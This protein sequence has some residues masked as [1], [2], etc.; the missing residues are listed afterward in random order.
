MTGEEVSSPT[1][2]SA[3]KTEMPASRKEATERENAITTSLV[4]GRPNVLRCLLTSGD[5]SG[6]VTIRNQ[7]FG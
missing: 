5:C 1:I 7:A 6:T 2:S 4:T 3:S